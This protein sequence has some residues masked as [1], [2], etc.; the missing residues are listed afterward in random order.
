MKGGHHKLMT[1]VVQET[2]HLSLTLIIQTSTMVTIN[3]IQVRITI[4]DTNITSEYS[5]NITG[6]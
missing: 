1:S 6:Y 3:S 4:T 2:L 5:L